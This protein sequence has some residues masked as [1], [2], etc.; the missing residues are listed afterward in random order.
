MSITGIDLTDASGNAL[1]IVQ[2]SFEVDGNPSS[3]VYVDDVSVSEGLDLATVL[4][5][6]ST[7]ANDALTLDYL[8]AGSTATSGTDFTASSGSICIAAGSIYCS[9]D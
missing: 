7:A 1:T 3:V 4:V 9:F 5:T 6:R 8:T 2:S